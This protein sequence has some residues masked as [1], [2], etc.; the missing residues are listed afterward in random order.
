MPWGG[1]PTPSTAGD[2]TKAPAALRPGVSNPSLTERDLTVLVALS[3]DPA[4]ADAL[5]RYTG[6]ADVDERLPVLADNGLVRETDAGYALTDSGRRVIDAPGGDPAD[7]TVDAP[8]EVRE[9]LRAR[10]LRADRLDAVLAA[11]GF[12]RYWG[13]ATGAEVA[14]GAF[15]EVPLDYDTAAEWWGF[16]ADHLAGV[17]TVDPPDREGGFWRFTG[18]PGVA[19]LSEDGRNRLFDHGEAGAYA[20]AT[21]AMVA[22]GLTDDDRRAVSAALAALQGGDE[23]DTDALRSAVSG[24]GGADEAGADALLDALERLPGVVRDGERWRY[25]LTPDGYE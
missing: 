16:V 3:A 15:G 8:D 17:P 25:T 20:S 5:A 11:F 21:E 2:T 9:S 22:A 12:L 13:T 1:V 19:D 24:V 14:D 7:D 4:D 10:D 23:R 6:L 18:R